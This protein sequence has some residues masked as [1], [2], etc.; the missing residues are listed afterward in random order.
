MAALAVFL[1]HLELHRY[2]WKATSGIMSQKVSTSAVF[3]G[4]QRIGKRLTL[5]VAEELQR[6]SKNTR[7]VF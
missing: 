4:K 2:F 1:L 3:P 5:L 7:I 6:N